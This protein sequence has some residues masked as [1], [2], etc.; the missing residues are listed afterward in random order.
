MSKADGKI[1]FRTCFGSKQ[2]TLNREI[3]AKNAK[4]DAYRKRQ[5]ELRRDIEDMGV[6]GKITKYY[7]DTL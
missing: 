7:W 1:D 4:I 6:L 5:N 2:V 3:R